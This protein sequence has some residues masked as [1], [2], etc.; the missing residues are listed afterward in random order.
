ML[1]FIVKALQ[2]K[3]TQINFDLSVRKN[4]RSLTL[5]YM[6]SLRGGFSEAISRSK[7]EKPVTGDCS[8]APTAGAVSSRKV[9]L[10]TTGGK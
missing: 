2:Y 10:A 7:G 9:L 8:P 4:I 3:T 5:H 6:M 1:T